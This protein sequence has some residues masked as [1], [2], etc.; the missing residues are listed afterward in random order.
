MQFFSNHPVNTSH[1]P[2]SYEYEDDAYSDDAHYYSHYSNYDNGYSNQPGDY[3]TGGSPYSNRQQADHTNAYREVRGDRS[4]QPHYNNSSAASKITDIARAGH[5]PTEVLVI[6]PTSFEEIPCVVQALRD[7]KS[8]V[9]NLAAMSPDYTQRAID[10]ITGGTHA[11]DGNYERIG[12]E[13]FLF[14]P[15]CVQVSSQSNPT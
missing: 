4:Q 1:P 15:S 11:M 12:E 6:K 13:I 10:F 3:Y 8:V 9:L 14:T 7:Y 5:R 2:N